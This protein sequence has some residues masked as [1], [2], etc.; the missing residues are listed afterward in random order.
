MIFDFTLLPALLAQEQG[1]WLDSAGRILFILAFLAAVTVLPFVLGSM[2]ARALRMRGYEWRIGL[3]LFS[4]FLSVTVLGRS[5]DRELGRLKI[6][7][8]VDLKGGVI[9]IYEVETESALADAD[10]PDADAPP[11]IDMNALTQALTNRINPSGTK[12]IVIRPYGDR[13][14]EIIIPEVDTEEVRNI[15]RQISTAGALEFRIVANERDHQDIIELARNQAADP[16]PARR[17]D[18]RVMQGREQVGLWAQAAKE[19]LKASEVFGTTARNGSNGELI[20]FAALPRPPRGG[21]QKLED[22]LAENGL[23]SIDILVAT[24]DGYNVTGSD[25]GVVSAGTDEYLQPCVNFRLRGA[26]IAKFRLLTTDNLPDTDATPP[27]YRHLGIMLD[28]RLLSFPRLITT[29]SDSGRITGDFPQEEVDFLVGILRAGR[30][31]AT[32]TKE[33]ISENTI[34]SMLGDDTIQKGQ[35]SIVVS[36]AAVLVFVAIYYQFAGI[37]ACFALLTNLVMIVATMVLLNA[38]LTLPG[39]AGLVLTVGMSVDANVLIFERIR[40]EMARGAAMRMAIRNGF[41]K[42]TTTIVDANVTTLITAMVLY[43][44]GTDQIRGFAVTLILGILMSMYTAIFCSRVIFDIAERR[45]WITQLRMMRILGTTHLDFIALQRVALIG[46]IVMVVIGVVAVVM[47]GRD[48]FDIDFNGGVSVTMVLQE[49]MPPDEVRRRL[50][51]HFGDSSPPIRCTVNTVGVEGR[52]D[53]SVY[54][55]DAPLESTRELERAIQTTFRGP[56]GDS[57][58]QAYRMDFNNVRSVTRTPEAA[59]APPVSPRAEAT[60]VEPAGDAP[61]PEG[62]GG[63]WPERL[64]R[65]TRSRWSGRAVASGRRCHVETPRFAL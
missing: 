32:L 43:A 23:E 50:D 22:F 59:E 62:S 51:D 44:I 17:I 27:F 65:G 6:P 3:I 2:I 25:L 56:A 19:R 37:V 34:G 24:N 18:R 12:E 7:L 54:K 20:D 15:K 48:I 55:I 38:P 63:A 29:I 11:S 28:E 13:Q 5:W 60:P 40:E 36:L 45:H 64:G 52:P 58:L 30:L 53:N 42:A 10:A 46:S 21:R 41:A 8:G 35:T 33:P 4:I 39:L 16:D 9:L 61:V 57:L 31:P 47:R 26:G 49:S 14:V 1:G